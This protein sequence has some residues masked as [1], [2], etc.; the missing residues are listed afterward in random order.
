[1]EYGH[2]LLPEHTKVT[3]GAADTEMTLP[4][5]AWLC[6]RRHHVEHYKQWEEGNRQKHRANKKKKQRSSQDGA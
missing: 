1:M 2:R 4:F 6:C 5:R 3:F